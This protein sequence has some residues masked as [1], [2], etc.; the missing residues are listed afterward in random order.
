RAMPTLT[1]EQAQIE[2]R[3]RIRTYFFSVVGLL[4]VAFLVVPFVLTVVLVAAGMSKEQAGPVV[5]A[6][7]VVSML[8][9]AAM[10]WYLVYRLW[11]CPAC[12]ANI[13]WLVS[14]NMSFF[15]GAYGKKSCPKCGIELFGPRSSRR[16]ILVLLG[17]A[18]LLGALG[19]I[20]SLGARRPRTP[21]PATAPATP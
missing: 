9:V 13:Y 16:F 3:S 11:R 12:D 1:A 2:L 18:L 8:G 7:V 19:A 10:S 21:A 17:I 4:L 15:A 20:M 14:W 6:S 5:G